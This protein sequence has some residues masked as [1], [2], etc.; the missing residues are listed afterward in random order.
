MLADGIFDHQLV[1]SD[2][3]GGALHEQEE[4]DRL[5][6]GDRRLGQAT[7]EVI[8]DHHEL[9]DIGRVEQFLEFVAERVD[10]LWQVF[11]ILGR[12]LDKAAGLLGDTLQIVDRNMLMRLGEHGGCHVVHAL[13]LVRGRNAGG[14][15]EGEAAGSAGELQ[16]I[17]P[18]QN[19]AGGLRNLRRIGSGAAELIDDRLDDDGLRVL[20]PFEGPAIEPEAQHTI[21]ACEGGLGHFEDTGFAGTP[22]AV[23]ADCYRRVGGFPDQAHHRLRDRLIVEEVGGRLLIVQEHTFPFVPAT[24]PGLGQ[25]ASH[26]SQGCSLQ[27]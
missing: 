16:P 4:P 26:S 20:E 24:L 13:D 21:V 14:C 25:P 11:A 3:E 7:I 27:R 5:Q 19:L 15:G 23:D 12:G 9:V 1:G 18:F 17:D 8:D 22:I 6:G 10:V 2:D